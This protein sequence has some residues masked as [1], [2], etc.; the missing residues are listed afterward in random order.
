MPFNAP[1]FRTLIA[2]V[3][4]GIIV[5]DEHGIMNAYNEA[6]ETLFGDRAEE[7]LGGNVNMLMPPPYR[8]EHDRCLEHYRATGKKRIIG[9]GRE[10]IGRRKEGTTFPMYFSVGEGVLEGKRMF[11]GVV[12]DL[13]A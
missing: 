8:D 12:H 9:I 4:D 3:A 7:V 11:V 13:T 1:L 6:A 2:T 5:I 10:V